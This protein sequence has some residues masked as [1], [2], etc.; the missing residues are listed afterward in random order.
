MTSAATIY[1]VIVPAAPDAD[2]SPNARIHWRVRAK[3]VSAARMMSC[4]AARE[5]LCGFGFGPDPVDVR[6]RVLWPKGRK[7]MDR[8]NLA[9]M[10][11]AHIDGLT[12]SGA[13]FDDK[14]VQIVNVEQVL[15]GKQDSATRAQYPGG[16]TVFDLERREAA[17]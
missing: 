9:Y 17:E 2:L 12:D 8:T 10:V 1:R 5:S 16:C 4:W 3:A 14:E 15:W 7:Q 11:K 13:W 6:L